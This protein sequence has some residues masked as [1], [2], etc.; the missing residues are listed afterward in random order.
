MINFFVQTDSK[1][2]SITLIEN[3]R[4]DNI[5]IT[6]NNINILK[7][8]SKY[9]GIKIHFISDNINKFKSTVSNINGSFF[10]I[11]HDY[12]IEK[13]LHLKLN[14]IK[15]FIHD[16]KNLFDNMLKISKIING[17]LDLQLYDINKYNIDILQKEFEK[18]LILLKKIKDFKVLQLNSFDLK[19]KFSIF[20]DNSFFLSP[21]LKVFYHP[22]FYY[23][24]KTPICDF[25][26][27]DF[28][29]EDIFNEVKPHL[30]CMCCNTFYCD[31]DIYDNKINTSEYK[32]PSS[33]QCKQT[34]FL[35]HYSKK[36]YNLMYNEVIEDNN[37]DV[38]KDFDPDTFYNKIQNN[39]V[40]CNIIKNISFC[41]DKK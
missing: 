19:T 24:N 12:E 20:G 28:L 26:D 37:L 23:L 13:Y 3:K 33:F 29:N 2:P 5:I 6:D 14:N 30:I 41:Q 35:S 27:L 8:M 22:N 16:E 1:L 18:V 38:V 4:I 36:L 21:D 25:I 9:L 10:T 11:I 31:R 39:D 34:T 40:K 17:V 7:N 15:L 32:V